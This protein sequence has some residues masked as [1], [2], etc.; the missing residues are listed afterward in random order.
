[1]SSRRPEQ[2]HLMMIIY[3]RD[4]WDTLNLN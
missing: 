4:S 3:S 1:M 2:L